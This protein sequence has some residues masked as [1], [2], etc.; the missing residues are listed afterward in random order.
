MKR[1]VVRERFLEL[2]KSIFSERFKD[3]ES[4]YATI[5]YNDL[6]FELNISPTYAQMLLKV[7][8]KSVGG[9]YTAGRCVVHRDDF[10]NA[11]KT[12]EKI[13]WAQG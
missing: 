7:Y 5:H 6:A 2:L 3:A 8:C 12:K 4:V 1:E 9:R 11:L 13:E 10:F